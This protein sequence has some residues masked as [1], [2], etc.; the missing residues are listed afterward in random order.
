MKT[1]GLIGGLSWESTQ[2]YYKLLNQITKEK[3]GKTHSARIL[4]YSF[5]WAEIEVLLNKEDFKTIGKRLS[6][7]AI[8]IEKAGA[9]CLMLCANTAHRWADEVQQTIQIPIIHI[10]NATGKHIAEKKIKN[11]LLLGTKYTMEGDFIRK[12]IEMEYDIKVV[13]PETKDR[14]TVHN[15]IYDELIRS[16]FLNSSKQ[17]ILDIINQTNGIEGVILGCTELPILIKPQDCKLPL[18]DTTKLHA[19]A[20]VQ[21]ATQH[22]K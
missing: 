7:E 10:A 17:R 18:F 8:K 16:K 12:K 15:I 14:T 11:V 4:M 6:E 9:H 22:L 2:E 5:D 3:A 13:V 20:A 21:F 1:I 19:E